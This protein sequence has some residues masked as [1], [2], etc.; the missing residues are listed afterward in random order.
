MLIVPYLGIWYS[1]LDH[2]YRKF[3]ITIASRRFCDVFI[4]SGYSGSSEMVCWFLTHDE[5]RIKHLLPSTQISDMMR[6][7]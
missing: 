4:I 7:K 5:S 3:A 1:Y 2:R 6:K